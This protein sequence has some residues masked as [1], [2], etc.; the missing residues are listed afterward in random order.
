MANPSPSK[1]ISVIFS[2][3]NEAE[4]LPELIRRTRI[5][6]KNALEAG[7]ISSYEL[8][9]VDDASQDRS[10]E[11]LQ[12]NASGHDDIRILTMSRPFG[13]APC[14]IAGMKYSTGDCVVYLDTDLQDPPEII[15]EL[16]RAW[17]DGQD[18]DVVHTIRRTRLGE[19]RLKILIT[20]LGYW[21]LNHT[22][23]I[24]L[25]KEAGD[26]KL[27]SRRVV[28]HITQFK[29]KNPF[30]RGLVCWAG[31]NQIFIYYDRHPRAAGKTKFP[32]LSRG[33][34][35]NFFDSALIS[36]SNFPLKLALL[37]GSIVFLGSF[38]LLTYTIVQKIIFPSQTGLSMTLMAILFLG[39]LQ[40]MASGI[41]GLY[42]NSIFLEA[43][44]RPNYIIKETFGFTDPLAAKHINE[45]TSLTKVPFL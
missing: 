12:Q 21:I 30:I 8:I 44:G 19:S 41:L 17:Q 27:L 39:G 7:M 26:F 18:I 14:I 34:I 23:D 15:P 37:A 38:A 5:V 35:E 28:N 9:F 16:L 10:L 11:I 13:V 31:F 43:K 2:F 36:F 25:P 20:H 4:V 32:V 22:T 24:A 3:R 40:L 45:S 42:L 1:K 33:V 29:E 6:F